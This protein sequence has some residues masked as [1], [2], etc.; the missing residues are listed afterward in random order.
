MAIMLAILV[1]GLGVGQ[2]FD[3]PTNATLVGVLIL[4][5]V[6]RSRWLWPSNA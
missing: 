5:L 4:L 6:A 2:A 1:A 3:V